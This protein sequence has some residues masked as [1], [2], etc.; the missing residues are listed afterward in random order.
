M[1]PG[2]LNV[3]FYLPI[4]IYTNFMKLAGGP[5]DYTENMS[6]KMGSDIRPDFMSPAELEIRPLV[7]YFVV[8]GILDRRIECERKLS[9]VKGS[10]SLDQ[11]IRGTLMFYI[12]TG[13]S[14][15]SFQADAE[16]HGSD[17]RLF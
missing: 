4:R 12:L 17:N 15:H 1:L 3:I 6:S 7:D 14:D 8:T 10:L 2:N 9:L 11:M 16:K 13:I 5:I